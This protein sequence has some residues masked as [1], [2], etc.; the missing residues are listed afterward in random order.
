VF[1]EPLCKMKLALY[2]PCWPGLALATCTT[3]QECLAMKKGNKACSSRWW[4]T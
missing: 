1:T 2:V 4:L 3:A